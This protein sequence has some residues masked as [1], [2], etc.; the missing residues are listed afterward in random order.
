ML[1]L[2]SNKAHAPTL[3]NLGS[4]L[5]ITIDGE[6]QEKGGHCLSLVCAKQTR[7]RASPPTLSTL[8]QLT[9]TL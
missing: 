9:Y 6:G 2:V 8:G 3:M 5:L 1:Q 7:G 4:T